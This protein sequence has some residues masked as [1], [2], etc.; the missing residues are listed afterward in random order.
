MGRRRGRSRDRLAV[1]EG[2][3]LAGTVRA[4]PERSRR[5][6]RSTHRT[7]WTSRTRRS[8][9]RWA[10]ARKAPRARAG[11]LPINKPPYGTLTAV[12]L[13]TGDTKWTVT[14][15]DSPEIR[16]NPALKGVA[17]AGKARRGRIARCARDERRARLR[18]RRRDACST[19]STRG[20]GATLW[21]YDLGQQGVRE[22]DD[23][24]NARRAAVH[25]HRDRLRHDVTARGVR[26]EERVAGPHSH[27]GTTISDGEDHPRGGDDRA[28]PADRSARTSVARARAG[29]G[30]AQDALLRGLRHRRPPASRKALGRAVS[31]R[32]RPRVHRPSRGDPRHGHRHRRAARSTKATSSPFS[33]CTRP[34]AAAT[35]ASSRSR[36]RAVRRERSTAS[37][38]AWPTDRSAAGPITSG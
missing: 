13:N 30:D 37:R 21:E 33:T 9:S 17:A 3:E 38:T 25:R 11:S 36:P 19:R 16:A 34:A 7:W 5:A 14:L 6:T 35:S 10:A 27:A 12:D 18:Q 32:A 20:T 23:L 8:A 24:S 1:R 22:P 15:G 29:R 31:D 26:A 2:H 28:A 4:A